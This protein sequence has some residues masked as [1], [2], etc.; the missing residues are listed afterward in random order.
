MG[1]SNDQCHFCK[2]EIELLMHLFYR[3]HTI[4]HVLNELK[5]V[6]KIIFEKNIVL[7]EE[8]VIIGTHEGE[9][10]AELLLVNLIICI[11]KWVIW[12]TRNDIKYNK[13][14]YSEI[15]VTTNELRSIIQMMIK[16][17][18]VRNLYDIMKLQLLLDT[19]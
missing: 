18:E 16:N 17:S 19:L 9:I 5:H 3:C 8:N 12:K 2:N 4:K 14:I 6:V 11:S 15:I 1:K 7:V 13:S 10:T